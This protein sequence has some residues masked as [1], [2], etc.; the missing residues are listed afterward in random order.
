MPHDTGGREAI[1][2]TS[3]KLFNEKGYTGVSIRDIAQTCGVTNAAL[4]YHFKNKEDLYVAVMRHNHGKVMASLTEGA[5]LVG[6]L[7]G[8][9]KRLV[10]R[11]AQVMCAQHQSFHSM[12]RDMAHID[13]ARAHKLF[14]EMRAD[15]MRPIQQLIEAEQADGRI[16]P[17][18]ARL[19]ARLLH[20]MIIAMAFEGRLGRPMRVTPSEA[21]VLVNVFLDGV[22]K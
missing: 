7:R 15:T 14:G 4:Y 16:V 12:R 19:L 3:A 2:E 13:D 18:D 5:E 20:G 6:D 17:G 21:D 1:L 11:Y 22:G 8:R 9:L 10:S